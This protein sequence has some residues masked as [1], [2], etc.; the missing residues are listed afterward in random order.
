MV[1]AS[2]LTERKLNGK[3]PEL[4]KSSPS[5]ASK[6]PKKHAES[7]KINKK[8]RFLEISSSIQNEKQLRDLFFE[9]NPDI[10]ILKSTFYSSGNTN[11]IPKTTS[12][13]PS[14]NDHDF[15]NA[16]YRLTKRHITFE[17]STNTFTNYTLCLNKIN[18]TTTLEDIGE[19]F[20]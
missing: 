16:I 6:Y 19:A 20:T 5:I 2:N 12:V 13:Y 15:N 7:A 4:P 1:E 10:K 8:P 11:I 18:I 3:F 17:E 9:S 14:I